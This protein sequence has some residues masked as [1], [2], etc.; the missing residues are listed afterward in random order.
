M[1]ASRD[2]NGN[3]IPLNPAPATTFTD[4]TAKDVSGCVAEYRADLGAVVATVPVGLAE[5]GLLVITCS[6]GAVGGG[7]NGVNGVH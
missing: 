1:V 7:V 2:N 6:V 3:G 5:G 4:G